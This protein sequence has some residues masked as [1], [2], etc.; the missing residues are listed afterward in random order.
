MRWFSL[1]SV[2]L[3]CLCSCGRTDFGLGARAGGDTE[4]G[5]STGP[6]DIAESG[7][8]TDGPDPVC[9]DATCDATEDCATCPAD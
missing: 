5:T 6:I 4:T 7:T 2:F 3:L 8:A 9:G 1:L